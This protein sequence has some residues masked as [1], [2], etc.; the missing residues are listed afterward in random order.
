MIFDRIL[1]LACDVNECSIPLA[2][3]FPLHTEFA[4]CLPPS[5]ISLGCAFVGGENRVPRPRRNTALRTLRAPVGAP[6]PELA[7]AHRV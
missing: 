2:T 3:H 4:A 6:F 7:H 1:A 5:A